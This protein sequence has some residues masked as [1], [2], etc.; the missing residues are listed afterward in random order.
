MIRPH[1][2]TL[3]NRVLS[4]D[5]K[6]AILEDIDRYKVIAISEVL[7]KDIEN[8]AR[9][10]FS[11]LTG[12]MGSEDFQSV[13]NRMR[14]KDDIPWTLPIVLDVSQE[15]AKE[16][17]VGNKVILRY[18]DINIGLL[19]VNEIY[20]Y[21]AD[22]MAQKVYGTSDRSHP[23]VKNIYEMG[24]R[25]VAGEIDLINE[26]PKSFANY[27]LTPKETR[28]LFE[29]K[30][31]KDVVGFQTRNTPHLGHEYVQKTALSFV[32]G[33]FINPLIG[34]KK[35]GDF[36]D[37]VIIDSYNTLMNHYYL[38]DN[39]VMAILETEMRYGGP[40]EAVFHCI[41]RK[42]F[43][44]THFIIGRD[45]AGVGDFYHPYASHDIFEE[46]PDLEIFP[47]FFKS[48]S[49]CKKCGSIVNEKTCPHPMDDHIMFSGT[50]IR[51]FL[52]NGQRPP[53]SQM[54]PEVADT[55]LKYKN[56]FIE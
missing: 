29:T 44:C 56:P 34:K 22:E 45:H 55:I 39:A 28:V 33:I 2:G 46:F 9:G 15:K 13:L 19:T 4:D 43:G 21:D 50:K 23:G 32:D 30:G 40:R 17:S 26:T 24:D 25:L 37:E 35:P 27:S 49:Y 36:K 48:F 18:G 6:R 20:Q 12:F 54:R 11:P 8:I 10:V 47:I 1:G 31:W 42:N 41:M 3:I 52:N 7:A 38:K 14:L 51:D 16:L 5:K 53:E